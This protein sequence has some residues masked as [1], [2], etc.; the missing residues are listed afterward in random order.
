MSAKDKLGIK[1][2][3]QVI[4]KEIFKDHI[5]C[6]MLIPFDKGNISAYLM[7]NCNII[8]NKYTSDG[9]LLEL[10]CKKSDYEK[11]KGYEI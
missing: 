7:E 1:A 11:Y 9:N 6:K 4:K 10:E 8:S 3:T 2:L 5:A